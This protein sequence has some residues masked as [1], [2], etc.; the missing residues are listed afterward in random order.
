MEGYNRRNKDRKVR[1]LE[2]I[3]EMEERYETRDGNDKGDELENIVHEL[4]RCIDRT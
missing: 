1:E 3:I 4:K 2:T